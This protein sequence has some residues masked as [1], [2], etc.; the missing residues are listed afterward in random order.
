M[1]EAVRYLM[2]YANSYG[3]S[4]SVVSGYRSFREQVELYQKGRSTSEV[5]NRVA[6]H[7]AGGT[8]TD[9]YAGESAHNYGLAVDIEGPNQAEILEL[10]VAIG[11][12]TVTWDPAHIEWPNWRSLFR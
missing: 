2:A 11:F 3:L 12:Q 8:V 10:A 7:G 6:K 4:G 5:I 1:S 9:A